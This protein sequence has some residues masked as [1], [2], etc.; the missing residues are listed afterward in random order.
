VTAPNHGELSLNADGSFT[1]T[2]AT[3][4][5]GKDTFSYQGRDGQGAS[6][7][8]TVTISVPASAPPVAV[9]PAEFT[10]AATVAQRT[11]GATVDF[12]VGVENVHGSSCVFQLDL[13]HS[14]IPDGQT[15]PA[16]DSGTG[17]FLWTPSSTGRFEIR[18]IVVKANGE[19][20]QQ[21]FLIDIVS[22]SEVS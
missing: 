11:V 1:Y 10:D 18:V 17:R 21:S 13:E 6:S 12:T 14:G 9:L 3:D 5:S 22:A 8:G 20:D 4:F 7:V 16:I 19:A 2:P 15:L